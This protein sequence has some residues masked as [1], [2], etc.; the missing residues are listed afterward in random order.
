VTDSV[1]VTGEPLRAGDPLILGAVLVRRRL[2]SSD[3]GL[4]YAGWLVDRPVT[5]AVL[6]EGASADPFGRAR[7][8][9]AGQALLADSTR[10]VV[11]AEMDGE[12]V[13]WVAIA[14]D[15]QA[16][17][18]AAHALL[19]PVTLEHLA[20]AGIAHGPDFRPSWYPRRNAGRSRPW[21]L[22]GASAA[23]PV[24]RWTYVAALTLT[25]MLSCLSLWV[26]TVVF[27]PARQAPIRAPLPVGSLHDQAPVTHSPPSRGQCMVMPIPKCIEVTMHMR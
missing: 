22:P 23:D 1:C 20:S 14:G 19:A 2:A 18:D 27:A 10:T 4:V 9:Q 5:V 16:A 11:A 26:A 6:T 17:L 12:L 13:P 8:R 15:D 7:F 21:P 3:A 25:I 24:G